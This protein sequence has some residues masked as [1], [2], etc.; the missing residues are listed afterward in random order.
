MVRFSNEKVGGRLLT[1]AQLSDFNDC[2]MSCNL[3]DIR[4]VGGCWT[5]NNKSEG[6]RRISGRLDRVLCND[7]WI[8]ALQDSYYEYSVQSTSDYCSMLLHLVSNSNSGPKPLEFFNYWLKCEGYHEV[9][10]KAWSAQVQG[11][12]LYQIAKKLRGVKE[13]IKQWTKEK[14]VTHK[15][16]D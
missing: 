6:R 7:L 5:W 10:N 15:F 9:I 3:V 8:T 16:D 14:P 13:A 1:P 2:I 12:P 11:F 4:S